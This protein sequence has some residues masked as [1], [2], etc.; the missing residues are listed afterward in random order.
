MCFPNFMLC[1][2]DFSSRSQPKYQL[3]SPRCRAERYFQWGAISAAGLLQYKWSLPCCGRKECQHR[4]LPVFGQYGAPEVCLPADADMSFSLNEHSVEWTH[5]YQFPPDTRQRSFSPFV[6]QRKCHWA[7]TWQNQGVSE[8]VDD[9]LSH[10]FFALLTLCFFAEILVLSSYFLPAR[11]RWRR[12]SFCRS[13][14]GRGLWTLG[15]SAECPGYSQ[16]YSG[17]TRRTSGFQG[18]AGKTAVTVEGRWQSLAWDASCL[19]HT[20]PPPKQTI[21]EVRSEKCAAQNNPVLAACQPQG[22]FGIFKEQAKKN[23]SFAQNKAISGAKAWIFF[24]LDLY[25]RSR[26]Q[27]HGLL[28]HRVLGIDPSHISPHWSTAQNNDPPLFSMKAIKMYGKIWNKFQWWQHGCQCF[29]PFFLLCCQVS[30]W[31]IANQR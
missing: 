6:L 5:H 25:Q 21:Q 9:K 24:P 27:P 29:L 12:C 31:E 30:V 1:K 3:A 22:L 11:L 18:S 2:C 14:K 8:W 13:P 17:T 20:C 28:F 26:W 4:I 7:L 19:V 16:E 15:T 23:G 10:S